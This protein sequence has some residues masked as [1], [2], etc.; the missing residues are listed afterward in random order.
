M[1]VDGPLYS[2]DWG[3]ETGLGSVGNGMARNGA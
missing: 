1:A 2:P 3:N